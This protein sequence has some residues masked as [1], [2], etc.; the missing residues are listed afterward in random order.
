M[1]KD[2]GEDGSAWTYHDDAY[3]DDVAQT[4]GL[5]VYHLYRD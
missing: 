3:H 4:F 5:R 2:Q 1:G